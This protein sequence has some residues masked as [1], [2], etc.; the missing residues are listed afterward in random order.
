VTSAEKIE[1]DAMIELAPVA[2]EDTIFFT[3]ETTDGLAT[4]ISWTSGGRLVGLDWIEAETGRS[5]AG[6]ATG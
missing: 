4:L 2:R 5:I 1:R 3:F 6:C